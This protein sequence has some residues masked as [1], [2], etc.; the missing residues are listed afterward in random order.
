VSQQGD[1]DRGRQR[2]RGEQPGGLASRTG[3]KTMARLFWAAAAAAF[4]LSTAPALAQE[5]SPWKAGNYWNV[6][7]I[8][9]K[10]GATLTYANHLA[11]VWQKQQDFAKSKGWIS[12]YHVLSNPFP[13]EGEPDLYLITVTDRMVQSDESDKR[14]AEM[15]AH[16]KMTQQEM[17]AAAGQRAYDRTNV[18]NMQLREQVRR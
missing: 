9:V 14:N 1:R 3:V 17:V 12:G 15:R 6:S 18:G 2:Q 5:A 13:R 11:N 7:S 16:M 10:E 4:L 8:K